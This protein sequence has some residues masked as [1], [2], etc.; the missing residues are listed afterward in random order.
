[1]KT[2]RSR[3]T[4]TDIAALAQ[5]SSESVQKVLFSQ[6]GVT[7]DE[8]QRILTA[9]KSLH[10][11]PP[12]TRSTQTSVKRITLSAP[13]LIGDYVGMV[14]QAVMET[15]GQLGFALH[16]LIDNSEDSRL[17]IESYERLIKSG[18]SGGVI[19]LIPPGH[20]QMITLCRQHKHPFVMIDYNGSDDISQDAAIFV[21]NRKGVYDAAMHLASLGHQ[22]IGFITGRA[23]MASSRERL[24]GYYVALSEL[25][26]PTVPELVREGD[27]TR[28][29]AL[30][31]THE[32][33]ALDAPPTAI[34]ASNDIAA[35]GVMEAAESLGLKIGQ[36]LSLVGFDDIAFAS[37]VTPALTTVRQPMA[38]MGKSAVLM[39]AELIN[40][41][42]PNPLHREFET[43]LIVRQST[44][45]APR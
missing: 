40:N 12:A 24:Q 22:R 41:T 20:N 19:V 4:I 43:E 44:G 31:L 36:D 3:A 6:P 7:E 15:A 13:A 1:M 27:W 16:Q 26:I 30:Q 23:S 18:G 34:I 33:M 10:V 17:M 8:R 2:T 35:F 25:G 14:A 37:E 29:N 9:M 42:P 5:V 21:T 45:P 11:N 38:D 28:E 39:L 32:L